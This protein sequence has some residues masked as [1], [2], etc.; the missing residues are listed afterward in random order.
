MQGK[1]H[2]LQSFSACCNK[3]MYKLKLKNEHVPIKNDSKWLFLIEK[4]CKMFK[5]K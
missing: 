4:E 5:T 1:K 3:K 2:L